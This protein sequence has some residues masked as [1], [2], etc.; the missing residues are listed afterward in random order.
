MLIST[1]FEHLTHY[2]VEL[3]VSGT[4]IPG[5]CYDPAEEQIRF[6]GPIALRFVTRTYTLDRV[7]INSV[8]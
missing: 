3:I 7:G 4:F 2:T 5:Q 6:A 8:W 1:G